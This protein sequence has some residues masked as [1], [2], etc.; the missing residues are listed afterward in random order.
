MSLIHTTT[1]YTNATFYTKIQQHTVKYANMHQ[2]AQTCTKIHQHTTKY[3]KIQPKCTKTRK[4]QEHVCR[5][6]S[7]VF[8]LCAFWGILWYFWVFWGIL[9]PGSGVISVLYFVQYITKMLNVC[10]SSGQWVVI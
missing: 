2:N 6:F 8:F 10:W 1:R 4:K 9:G 3:Y 7:R 5:L